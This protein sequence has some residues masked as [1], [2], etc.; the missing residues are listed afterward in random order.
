[1]T[2]AE[3]KQELYLDSSDQLHTLDIPAKIEPYLQGFLKDCNRHQLENLMNN[4]L[5]VKKFINH[6]IKTSGQ[7][8]S[9]KETKIPPLNSLKTQTKTLSPKQELSSIL[10]TNIKK[11][12]NWGLEFFSRND[13][14]TS[15][16][17]LLLCH[18]A[19]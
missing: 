12:L 6:T 1:M 8:I 17:V 16:N 10:N 15:K 3:Q 14:I 11:Q 13:D 19:K 2:A 5:E 7:Q 4:M 18:S 9:N